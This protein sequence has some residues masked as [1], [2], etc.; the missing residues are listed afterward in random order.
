[1]LYL[2]RSWTSDPGRCAAAG[3]PKHV[4]FA[5]KPALAPVMIARALDARMSA[6]CVAGDEVYGGDPRLAARVEEFS[7]GYVLAIASS[8][9]MQVDVVHR[10]SA[11]S[12][13]AALPDSAFEERLAGAGAHGQR[14]HQ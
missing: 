14:Y 8:T 10:A 5:T 2:P 1:M 12:I 7:L 11:E 13:A 6:R 9:K 4:G 3:V